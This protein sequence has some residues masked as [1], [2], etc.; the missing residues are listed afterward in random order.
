MTQPTK[1]KHADLII[2]WALG[3][4]IEVDIYGDNVWRNSTNPSWNEN[5]KYQVKQQQQQPKPD[6]VVY[7]NMEESLDV[8][9]SFQ[10]GTTLCGC[11][12]ANLQETDNIKV[13]YSGETGKLKSIEMIDQE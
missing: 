5:Y 9:H 6:V 2:Q 10:Y 13:T 4:P 8:S 7:A 11:F 12:S 3:Q 1:H